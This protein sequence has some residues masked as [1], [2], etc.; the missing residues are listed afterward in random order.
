MK[1]VATDTKS[2][3]DGRAT[4]LKLLSMQT[5]V[6]FDHMTKCGQNLTEKDGYAVHWDQSNPKSP[7]NR[8]CRLVGIANTDTNKNKLA[9]ACYRMTKEFAKA[10][11][12]DKREVLV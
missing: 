9:M 11:V 3:W 8:S 6:L 7:A 10:P 5:P 12:N 1:R 4:M 2:Y